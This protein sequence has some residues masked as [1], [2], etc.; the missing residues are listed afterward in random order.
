MADA[1]DSKSSSRKGCEGSS[2]SSG[3]D[4]SLDLDALAVAARRYVM[5]QHNIFACNAFR[6]AEA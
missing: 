2:P 4:A 6:Y 5:L 3:T 1:L